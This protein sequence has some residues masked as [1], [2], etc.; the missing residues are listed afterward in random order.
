MMS[1][2][3]NRFSAKQLL[4]FTA[5]LTAAAMGSLF[6]A[7]LD[8]IALVMLG[9]FLSTLVALA[10]QFYLDRSTRDQSLRLQQIH[11]NLDDVA[12]TIT[13]VNTDIGGLGSTT[14]EVQTSISKVLERIQST[15]ESLDQL[16]DTATSARQDVLR[17]K[18][19]GSDPVQGINMPKSELRGLVL[20]RGR[21]LSGANLQDASW[22]G[23]EADD[24]V[25][26]DARMERASLE[27]TM[28]RCNLSRAFLQRA[29]LSGNF[30][31]C[32]FEG[33]ILEVTRLHGYFRYST[34]VHPREFSFVRASGADLRDTRF[35]DID[36]LQH[37]CFWACTLTNS[38]FEGACIGDCDF[39][40][41]VLR[42]AHITSD[43][44]M[45]VLT[46]FGGALLERTD[47]RGNSVELLARWDFVGAID[48]GAFWPEGFESEAAGILDIK[49]EA[50][51]AKLREHLELRENG[52][53]CPDHDNATAS[54][55]VSR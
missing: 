24:L 17:L 33:A 8:G 5:L 23:I 7:Q 43:Q 18:L 42:D 1:V 13:Q 30:P 4:S 15:T 25:L 32:T 35:A 14:A 9:F 55:A 20:A 12:T 37:S 11:Q 29:T 3:G 36:Y 40:W 2:D 19:S 10:L 31:R 28:M 51:L 41:S 45:N 16:K 27:G 46:S 38:V 21:D 34:F 6:G 39:R 50:G 52:L 54:A 53:P 48:D 26:S 44:G 22:T 47:F 49:S